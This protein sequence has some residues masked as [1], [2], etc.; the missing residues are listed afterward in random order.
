MLSNV[1]SRPMT[2]ADIP[3]VAALHDRVFGPG[4]FAR[5][6]YRVREAMPDDAVSPFCRLTASRD[7]LVAAVRMSEISIGGRAGALLLGPLVVAPEYENQGFGRALV[8]DA[9]EAA[10]TAGIELVV[11]IGDAPYYGRLGF[12]PAPPGT[13]TFPGPV[14]PRRILVNELT[15]GALVRFQGCVSAR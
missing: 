6:A 12:H 3:L 14:D 15:D 11:L 2:P 5:T 7:G 8:R 4:R 13:V 10:R 1:V 9:V